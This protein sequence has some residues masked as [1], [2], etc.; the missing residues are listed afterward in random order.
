[1]QAI[2][3]LNAAPFA[4]VRTALSRLLA[5]RHS[6]GSFCAASYLPS[7]LNGSGLG[8]ALRAPAEARDLARSMLEL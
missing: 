7:Q 8:W 2:P 6:R 5:R 3:C 1:V 4:H